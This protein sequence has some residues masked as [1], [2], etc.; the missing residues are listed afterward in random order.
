MYM[1]IYICIHIYLYLYTHIYTPLGLNMSLIVLKNQ[2]CLKFLR[3]LPDDAAQI[4]APYMSKP[5]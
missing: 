4:P 2:R 1:Y 3:Y 5:L